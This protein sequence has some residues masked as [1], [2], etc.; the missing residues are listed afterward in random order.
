[1]PQLT[2]VIVTDGEDTPVSH[3]FI[4]SSQEN[5][6]AVFLKSSG[7]PVGDQKLTV[8]LSKSAE[9]AKSE[10]V[11][12]LPVLVTETI[13]GVDRPKV[14]RTAYAQVKFNFDKHSTAQERENAVEM[15]ADALASDQ[16]FLREILVDLQGMY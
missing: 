11:F 7:V 5:G 3:T 10:L 2:P 8:S 9:R 15:M 4:P 16:T 13:N 14:E 6:K 12:A 1:M